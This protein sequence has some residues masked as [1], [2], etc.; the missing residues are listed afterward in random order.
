MIWSYK[1]ID[2]GEQPKP[3]METIK[4]IEEMKSG[5]YAGKLDASSKNSLLESIMKIGRR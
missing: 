5:R 4:A 3:K 2:K 1:V